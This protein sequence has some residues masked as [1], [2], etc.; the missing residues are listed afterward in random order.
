MVVLILIGPQCGHSQLYMLCV[1][2]SN[3]VLSCQSSIPRRLRAF[4]ID[5]RGNIS[6]GRLYSTLLT[7]YVDSSELSVLLLL[8]L[9]LFGLEMVA[10]LLFPLL[11][12]LPSV[13]CFLDSSNGVDFYNVFAFYI[14]WFARW[15]EP[16]SV[17][18]NC[19]LVPLFNCS[20]PWASKSF[21]SNSFSTCVTT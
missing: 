1:L 11:M 18:T 4:C 7:C 8:L 21:I 12:L 17:W 5:S 16:L 14:G 15:F 20:S 10:L 2:L 6:V 19:K 3:L 13:C 9:F